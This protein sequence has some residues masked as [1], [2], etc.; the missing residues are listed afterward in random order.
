MPFAILPEDATV[1]AA[2]RRIAREEAEGAL[3]E[4]RGTG[5]LAP[6]V[7]A[8]RKAVK[9]LRGLLRLVRPVFPD[10]KAENEVLRDAGRGLSDLRDAAVQLATIQRLSEDLPE[11]RRARLLAPFEAAAGHQD[12]EAAPRLLPAFAA[13][14]AGLRDRSQNWT[15]DAEGWDAF[16]P[17]LEATWAGARKGLRAARK[18]PSEDD[19]HEWRKR[20]KD[21]WYQARLLRPLWPAMMD[22]HVAAADD[23][24]EMLGQVNDLAVLRSRLDAAPLDEGL[25]LEARDLADLRHADLMARILPLGRRLLAGPPEALTARWGALWKLRQEP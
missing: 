8:M 4:V 11:D 19:L 14:M 7:H 20:V 16:E 18:S 15:L 21:H 3:S 22:P 10:A 23:L 12:Q 5:P 17:G 25:R 1:E 6:R 24:G 9:K 2:L 13:S